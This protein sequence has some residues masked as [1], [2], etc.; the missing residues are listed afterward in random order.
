MNIPVSAKNIGQIEDPHVK[1]HLREIREDLARAV[2]GKLT[3]GSP[4]DQA[5]KQLGNLDGVWPGTLAVGYTVT[6]PGAP[7]TE[8]TVTHNLGRVPIGYDV[9]SLDAA[10]IIYDSRKA[11]WTPTQMFLKCNAASVNLV[12]FVH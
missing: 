10:A 4:Q 12:L 2:N 7:N 8:F 5:Q 3:F 11:L 6:T 1:S 9:K